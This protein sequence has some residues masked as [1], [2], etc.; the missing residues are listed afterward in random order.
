MITAYTVYRENT[1]AT[2]GPT[3]SVWNVFWKCGMAMMAVIKDPSYPLAQAQQKA[4]KTESTSSATGR[5]QEGGVKRVACSQY[6]CIDVRL[7]LSI[8]LSAIAA[9]RSA[10]HQSSLP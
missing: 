10:Y 4:T 2:M 9:Y 7:H 8:L 6:R 5:R 1:T 3:V